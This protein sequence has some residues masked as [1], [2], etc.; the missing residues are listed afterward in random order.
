MLKLLSRVSLVSAVALAAAVAQTPPAD[1]KAAAK[2]EAKAAPASFTPAEDEDPAAPKVR[3]TILLEDEGPPPVTV[4]KGCLY[5]RIE[6][7]YRG[8]ADTRNGPIKDAYLK[9]A[10]AFDRVTENSDKVQ[11]IAPVPIHWTDKY[12]ERF[13]YFAMSDANAP[14]TLAGMD[15]TRVKKV[16]HF[17][18]IAAADVQ[19]LAKI[20]AVTGT[21]FDG[22]DKGDRLRAAERILAGVLRF[23][24]TARDLG[25]RKGKG[26]DKVRADVFAELAA[27]R[28]R[29]IVFATET[30]DWPTVRELAQRMLVLYPNDPKLADLIA[31]ARLAEAE[32]LVNT[33]DTP[34]ELERARDVLADFRSKFPEKKSAPAD[35]VTAALKRK[36]ARF[37]EN[38]ERAVKADAPDARQ[39]L[40]TVEL[41]D[42]DYPGLR[43]LQGQLKSGYGVIYVGVRQLPERVY[44]LS[45]RFDSEK[46]AVDLVYEG[47][48]DP[49][50]DAV[51][52][53]RYTPTL[54]AGPPFAAGL[55]RDIKLARGAEWAQS[56]GGPVGPVDAA[57]IA[58]TMK[59]YRQYRHTWAANGIDWFD[60]Q[61][62]V[63]DPTRAK[64]TFTAGHPFP[65]SLLA[66]KVLPARWLAAQQKPADDLPFALNPVGS[67]PY[68]LVVPTAANKGEV[69]FA[70]NALYGR[71]KDRLGQPAV[72]EIHFVDY[73]KPAFNPAAEFKA[74]KLHILH[75]ASTQQMATLTNPASGLTGRVQTFVAGNNRTAM[76]LA[77]NHRKPQL[78]SQ[79]LR[80]GLLHAID[81]ETILND[82][83]RA[84]FAEYHRAMAGPFPAGSWAAPKPVGGT[85]PSLYSK[86]LAQGKLGEHF[87]KNGSA[88]LSLVYPAEDPR[89]K[90]ACD[91]IKKMIE[92]VGTT[93]DG[94]LTINPEPLPTAELYRRVTEEFAFDLA[95]MP[96][97]YPDD[98]YPFGLAAF[99][100]PTAAD[101]GGRNYMSAL[102]KGIPLA[103]DDE[104]LG[105]RLAE[106]RTH[107]DPAR[108]AAAAA[109]IA[110]KFNESAPFVP[111]WQLDRHVIVAT[112]LKIY[113]E[114]R[115]EP[116]SPR[117][118]SPN[119]LFPEIGRW[120]VD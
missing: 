57:D 110:R 1:P 60:D 86:D 111:L 119:R 22:Q 114:D 81:R 20:D 24:D 54:A 108:L 106:V 15:L 73:T 49:V 96:F 100:D 29:R 87:R 103:P 51:H 59:I 17:E 21:P 3:K 26:W 27:V 62:R 19:K 113:L 65:P 118:L 13:G 85:F 40:R 48:L 76:I 37:F 30:Q 46:M 66:M 78:Q 18:E 16:D 70:A 99:L 39:L 35:R 58:G 98:L 6:D 64:L 4:P 63:E 93:G 80:R 31:D 91:R 28:G 107:A 45:A 120:R 2:P 68:R 41:L 71:R 52:G 14:R 95:Y 94:K 75:D 11:R 74:D 88:V 12:P 104:Q 115:G 92:E 42:P 5:I 25:K 61:P 97:E 23:H 69:V 47:L 44:P 32:N 105:R 34:T 112:Q 43:E 72:K 38:A 50:P 33:N 77:I 36:A 55:V 101:R 53:V 8:G 67:G 79:G 116:A 89:A 82:I 7:L 9:Y 117:L 84:N 10:V 83:Y 56:N 102:A 109:E 90:Q